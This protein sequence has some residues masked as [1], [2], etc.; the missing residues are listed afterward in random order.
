MGTYNKDNLRPDS[1]K[2]SSIINTEINNEVD[3]LI[4][5]FDF[6]ISTNKAF[7][8]SAIQVINKVAT[9]ITLV[10]YID[11]MIRKFEDIRSRANLLINNDRL[12]I[13]KV[14]SI[15]WKI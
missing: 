8:E 15:Y 11:S 2:V 5:T 7:K 13:F 4:E 9:K 3:I 1:S 14:N 10:V 12:S 6:I